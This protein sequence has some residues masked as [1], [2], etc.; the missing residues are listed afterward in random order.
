MMYD[1]KFENETSSGTKTYR[2]ESEAEALS[3]FR[4]SYE[5]HG[6]EVPSHW[7]IGTWVVTA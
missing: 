1:I 7:V 3:K 5:Q 2:A 4:E 6:D